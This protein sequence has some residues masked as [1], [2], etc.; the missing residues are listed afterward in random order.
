MAKLS[1]KGMGKWQSIDTFR[2]YKRK[3]NKKNR[4]ARK[5]RRANR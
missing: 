4:D 2:V 3:R 1:G 5:S